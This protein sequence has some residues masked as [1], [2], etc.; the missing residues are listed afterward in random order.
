MLSDVCECHEEGK[1][2]RLMMKMG[3][4]W[5]HSVLNTP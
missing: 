2:M 3:L 5:N 4:G 1:W